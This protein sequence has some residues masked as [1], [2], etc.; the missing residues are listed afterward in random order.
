MHDTMM[1]GAPW[2]ILKADRLE[3]GWYVNSPAGVYCRPFGR[4]VMIV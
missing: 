4:T 2:G 3:T 1:E